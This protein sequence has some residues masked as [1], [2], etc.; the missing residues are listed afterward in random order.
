[1]ESATLA[2]SGQRYAGNFKFADLLQETY[3][4]DYID[5]AIEITD[6]N[7]ANMNGVPDLSDP[8]AV[9]DFTP[10]KLA[11]STPAANARVTNE[12]L[13]VQGTA[14]DDRGVVAVLYSFNGAPYTNA[15]GTNIWYAS[16]MLQPGTNTF[17]V[18][19]LDAATN[20]SAVV[21]RKF[22]RYVVSPL[23]VQTAGSGDGHAGS[24]YL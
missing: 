15:L 23:T 4:R 13:V 14:S 7:D 22:F 6:T 10:P 16:V 5:W 17:L 20:T 12:S 19:A 8:L 9:P 3:W 2:R 11:I 21:T 1:M 18:K 24:P